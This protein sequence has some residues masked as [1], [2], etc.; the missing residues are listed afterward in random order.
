[1]KK[2][3]IAA[4]IVFA[5]VAV[6]VCG[7]VLV[8][9]GIGAQQSSSGKPIVATDAT[10]VES[11]PAAAPSTKDDGSRGDGSWEVGVTIAPGKWTTK[12]P[13]DGYGCFWS[14]NRDASGS[15]DGIITNGIIPKGAPG[16]VQIAA[17]DKFV[18]FSGGCRWVRAA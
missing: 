8:A 11:A 6:L 15:L 18:E 16:I 7:G 12:A 1:M 3:I 13:A 2:A 10:G 5:V 17:S 9:A 14:R 4:S